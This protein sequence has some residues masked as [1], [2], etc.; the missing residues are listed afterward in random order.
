MKKESI[1]I[2][3]LNDYFTYLEEIYNSQTHENIY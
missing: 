2:E 1:I 3:Q